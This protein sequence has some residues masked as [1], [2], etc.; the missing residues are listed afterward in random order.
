MLP[1][2]YPTYNYHDILL[3]GDPRLQAIHNSQQ[4]YIDV[5]PGFTCISSDNIIMR[6]VICFDGLNLIKGTARI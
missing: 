4:G 6:S 2:N 5:G 1:Y 3:F